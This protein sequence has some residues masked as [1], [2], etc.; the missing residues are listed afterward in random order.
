MSTIQEEEIKP[1]GLTGLVNIGNT[2]YMNSAIQALS[3]CPQLTHYFLKSDE[4]LNYTVGDK[5]N[6]AKCY[7]DLILQMWDRKRPK[8][9]TPSAILRAIRIHNSTFR[10][11]YQQD[12]QEF[13]RC[14]MDRIH[15]DLKVPVIELPSCHANCSDCC[16]STNNGK[17]LLGGNA[18]GE[19]SPGDTNMSDDEDVKTPLKRKSRKRTLSSKTINEKSPE[20]ETKKKE[21]TKLKEPTYRSIITTVFDGKLLSSVQCL[22]C[23]RIS[24]RVET[25]QDLSL[26]IP[27]I[28]D[29]K[30]IHTQAVI[31][32]SP[33][34]YDDTSFVNY[35][36]YWLKSWFV[37]P[38]IKLE[39]CLAAFFTNDELKGDNMYSCEKCKKLR[40]GLKYS[41]VQSLPEVLCIHLKRFR[42][43]L[44]Y[45]SK[46]NTYIS[47]PIRNLDLY[48]FLSKDSV[49]NSLPSQYDLSAVICHFGSV[50]GG[51]YIAYAK[52]CV[53]NKWYE[54]NDSLVSEV[55]EEVVTNSEAYVLF[56]CLKDSRAEEFRKDIT[57]R[58]HEEQTDDISY[59][60]KEWFTRYNS[61]AKAESMSNY[62]LLCE[63]GAIDPRDFPTINNRVITVPITVSK[64]LIE[65]F[66]GGPEINAL[67]ECE[68][69]VELS[70]RQKYELDKFNELHGNFQIENVDLY[71][72][73][74]VPWFDTWNDFANGRTKDIPGE[75]NNSQID[76]NSKEGDAYGFISEETWK[77]FY[78]RY[79]G[80]PVI[81]QEKDKE[82][83]SEN[84]EMEVDN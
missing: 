44:Y 32:C 83:E 71:Y 80:G 58:L 38:N 41:R 46:I 28:E 26:S 9:L 79:G 25:F 29:L 52:N 53:T 70:R 66:G 59:V 7:R 11:N 5:P 20:I 22:T 39:D 16:P 4:F 81:K 63:H 72:L 43:E 14:L 24:N 2:C 76:E 13:L 37:G 31:S 27:T 56:Y 50:G 45:S 3:N 57:T 15:E 73:I 61:C 67:R 33:N 12:T 78:S 77:F 34:I 69:C 30:R 23:N 51:H 64:A 84:E 40:N 42:H 55:D 82:K 60:S 18:S 36:W 49:K 10:G 21:D 19:E 17:G 48:C 74:S 6:V 1:R 65:R 35:M 8:S 62:D 68:Q 75:I 54:Y 47:F